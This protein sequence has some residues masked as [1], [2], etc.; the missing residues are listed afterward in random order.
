MTSDKRLSLAKFSDEKALSCEYNKILGV[1]FFLVLKVKYST[2]LIFKVIFLSQKS[3][4]A[5]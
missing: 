2:I 5:L 3:A 1:W 4:E